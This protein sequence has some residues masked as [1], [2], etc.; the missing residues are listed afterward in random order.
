MSELKFKKG[1]LVYYQGSLYTFIKHDVNTDASH[2]KHLYKDESRI[3]Y[4]SGLSTATSGMA[5]EVL[6]KLVIRRKAID[7]AIE[8]LRGLSK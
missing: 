7:S 5:V 2:V 3:V 4:T 6:K 8:L 1:E